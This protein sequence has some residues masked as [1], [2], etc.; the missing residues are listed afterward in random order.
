MLQLRAFSVSL[1]GPDRHAGPSLSFCRVARNSCLPLL[2]SVVEDGCRG[3]KK[4]A[5][6]VVSVFVS[7]GSQVSVDQPTSKNA[8]AHNLGKSIK[9]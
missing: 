2:V 7:W 5:L 8:R 6:P 3:L 1:L 4:Q 9:V